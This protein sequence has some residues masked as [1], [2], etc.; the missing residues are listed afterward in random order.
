MIDK[1]SARECIIDAARDIQ[2]EK[3]SDLSKDEFIDL[4]ASSIANILSSSD[5]SDGISRDLASRSIRRSRGRL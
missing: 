5:F 3:V 2:F 4:L 1:Q